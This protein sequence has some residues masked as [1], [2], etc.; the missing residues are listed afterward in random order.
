M[1]R[2][3]TPIILLILAIGIYFTFT[4][5]KIDELNSI[6][7]VN[8]KYQEALNN[9]EKLIK[10]R[11]SIQ[12]SYND[13]DDVDKNRL[14]KML[15]DNV[16]NVRLIIDVKGIGLQKGLALKNI[17]TS[18]PSTVNNSSSPIIS[19]SS[20]TG[21]V[22]NAIDS[23]GAVTLSFEVTTNYQNFIE[24]LKALQA[25]LRI[26]NISKISLA[27]DENGNYNYGV[28]IKTYWLKQK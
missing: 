26:M 24:L 23:Y 27:I 8:N 7:A 1:N 13:I 9:A 25:S 19:P 6:K 11:D 16:D 4:K 12:K 18:S 2:N 17:K 14:E 5:A 21:A 28:E 3:I 22:N 15:P 20:E 10:V